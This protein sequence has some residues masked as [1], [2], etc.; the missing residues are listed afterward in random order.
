MNKV[1]EYRK[2][3]NRTLEMLAKACHTSKGHLS[4]LENSKIKSP[5]VYLAIKLSK[6]LSVSVQKLFPIDESNSG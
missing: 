6:T 1:K 4:D 5:S 2:A 3:R